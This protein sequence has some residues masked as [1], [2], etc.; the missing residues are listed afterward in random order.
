MNYIGAVFLVISG[1][2]AGIIKAHSLTELEKTYSSLIS[3]LCFIKN[4]ISSL[5]APLDSIL[6]SLESSCAASVRPFVEALSRAFDDLGE[7]SF[8]EIWTNCVSCKLG[9]ISERG[10]RALTDLGGSLG[11]YDAALQCA[12]IERCICEICA[13]RDAL[14]LGLTANKRMYIGIGTASGLIIAIMLV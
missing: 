3:L 5:S 7:R 8:S 14:R 6:H 2:A 10:R 4:E 13:E 11:K 1:F 9:I 12:E